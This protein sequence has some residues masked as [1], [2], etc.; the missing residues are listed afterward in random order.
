VGRILLVPQLVLLV[1]SSFALAPLDLTLALF[2]QTF[3]FVALNKVV[4]AQYF[5]WYLCLLPLCSHRLAWTRGVIR[6]VA[7]LLGSVVFWL[8]SAYLLEMQ[9]QAV[10]RLVW[11]AS[12]VFFVAEVEVNLLLELLRTVKTRDVYHNDNDKKHE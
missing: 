4:T 10:N 8:G 6:A 11:F 12:V 5:T 9:G 1:Y 2:V 3:S 7:G